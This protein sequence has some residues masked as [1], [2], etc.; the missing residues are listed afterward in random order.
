[1]ISSSNY[2]CDDSFQ[3]LRVTDIVDFKSLNVVPK[4]VELQ[5]YFDKYKNSICIENASL[6]LPIISV[7]SI[8]NNSLSEQIKDNLVVNLDKEVE[9]NCNIKHI[10]VKYDE[11]Y[12]YGVFD[13][14]N[15]DADTLKSIQEYES[16]EECLSSQNECSYIESYSYSIYL[17]ISLKDYA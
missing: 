6:L 17:E 8:L 16:V 4:I 7:P 9:R 2:I 1:M 13:E 15:L 11:D 12:E 3:D 14:Y 5:N 10:S